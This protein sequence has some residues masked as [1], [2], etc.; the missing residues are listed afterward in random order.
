MTTELEQLKDNYRKVHTK[1]LEL[2][3]YDLA[4]DL[5]KTFWAYGH[6]NYKRG[7]Q[8]LQSQQDMINQA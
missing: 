7:M 5:S 6:E 3:Q 8:D 4:N 1:L 2:E